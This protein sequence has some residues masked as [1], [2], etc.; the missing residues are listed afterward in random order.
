MLGNSAM[1][2]E[3][4][5]VSEPAM[6]DGCYQITTTGE[7]VWLRDQ[8]NS[9]ALTENLKAELLNDLSMGQDDLIYYFMNGDSYYQTV[10][11]TI[12]YP[13]GTEEHPFTGTFIG[14]DH[15]IS[16]IFYSYDSIPT[17]AGLFGY[18][19]GGNI[20]NL[21]VNGSGFKASWYSGAIAGRLMNNSVVNRC[22][23]RC[24]AMFANK[25]SVGSCAGGIA[26]YIDATSKVSNCAYSGE[27]TARPDTATYCG[28]IA[29][30][31]DGIITS[32]IAFNLNELMAWHSSTT[33]AIC[34]DPV[35]V[36]NTFYQTVSYNPWG[37]DYYTTLEDPAATLLT[38]YDLYSGR[39][40]YLLNGEQNDT[41]WYQDL[42]SDYRGPIPSRS[43][44]GD[45]LPV[46]QLECG[47]YVNPI[48]TMTGCYYTI[49]LT[50]SIPYYGAEDLKATY[51]TYH[52]A[53][54]SAHK[55]HSICLP[56]TVYASMLDN[57][58]VYTIESRTYVTDNVSGN[59]I[60]VFNMQQADSLAPGQA[61]FLRTKADVTTDMIELYAPDDICTLAESVSPTTITSEWKTSGSF[62]GGIVG[63]I[64][65]ATAIYN[66]YYLSN[67]A[68]WQATTAVTAAPYRA[69]VN[70]VAA[71]GA[72]PV[73]IGF[74]IDNIGVTGIEE[75]DN[76][77]EEE[78]PVYDLN[79]N[80]LTT[81]PKSSLY[82]KNNQK[83][84]SR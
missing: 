20:S 70:Y 8:V 68:M 40:C 81:L 38:D 61:G 36:S 75:L 13:I 55:W 50:D 17:D 48:D 54:N 62:T 24:N 58:D 10:V 1:A 7:L 45:S 4:I 64:E 26:G 82:I 16:N 28:G 44:I 2:K 27:S 72:P 63:P 46:I 31:S 9:G 6:V 18:V 32:C 77:A 59:S 67:D 57:F 65:G 39:I 53:I 83:T 19:S 33:S 56:F 30:K 52:R 73:R 71:T 35:S 43:A 14:N 49:R 21:T 51:V 66:V 12:W 74:A 5:I 69:I 3:E 78:V 60:M 22:Y 37:G 15:Q 25:D 76:E 42:S 84:I 79:G 29:G 47:L 11:D 41:I 23:S 34:Y 80:V